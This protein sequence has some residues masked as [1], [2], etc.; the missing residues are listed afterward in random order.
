MT[1]QPEP[2]PRNRKETPMPDTQFLGLGITHYPLLAGKDED[3]AGLLRFTLRDPDIPEDLK[4]PAS[5]P[6]AMREE[7]G[8]DGGTSAAKGHREALLADLERCRTALDE[9]QPDVVL[10]WGDDQ[11]ENFREEIIPPFC[12]LAYPDLDVEAFAI[13]N[14]RG[15]DNVWGLPS[16]TTVT[17]RGIPEFA[18]SLTDKLIRAGVDLPYSYVNRA[19]AHFPHS[20]L[21]TQLFL[22]YDNAGRDFPYPMLPIT[23]NCYGEHAIARKGGLAHF[24]AINTET[25]DPSGPTPRRCFEFGG[26]IAR[27]LSGT[28]ASASRWSPRRAGLTPSSTTRAGTC[29]P[30]PSPTSGS[31]TRS[32]RTTSTTGRRRPPSRSWNRAS[33]RC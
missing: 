5:W 20:V 33:T 22:D 14:E 16:E 32:S 13:L 12:V 15:Q 25:L 17:L 10:V 3:M 26:Q 19:G 27:A 6:A 8:E 2:Q 9:F 29:G 30:T 21:N 11:Y 28:P 24:A 1:Q 23:V 4:D 7:W 18:R 31:T